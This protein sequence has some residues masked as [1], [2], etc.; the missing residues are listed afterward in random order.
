MSE[1]A[2]I[3]VVDDDAGTRETLRDVLQ[4]KGYAVD[5]ASRGAEGLE[6]LRTHPFDAAIVD[7]KLPDISGLEL[8]QALRTQAADI[9]VIFIT[10]Y[11]SLPTAIEAINGEAFAYLV[12]PFEMDHL[13]ATLHK[14]LNTQRLA[15]ALRES[16]ERYR[17]IAENIQDAVFLVDRESR[18]VFGNRRGEEISGY[19]EAEF[20]GR[21]ITDL[22]TPEGARQASER[23]AAA[24]SGRDPV[25]FFETQLVRKDGSLV[26]VEANMTTVVRHG[27]I[28]GR[29][30]V[31]RDISA[32]KRAEEQMRLRTTALEAAANAVV[33][34]DREGRIL[35]VNPAFTDL[36]GYTLAEAAGQTPRILKSGQH[37]AAFYRDLWETILAGRTWRGEIVNRHKDGSLC[38]EEQVLTSVRDERG[39]ITHF[40]AIKQ[41]VSERKRM[42]AQLI[43]SEKLAAMGQLLAGVAH[44]L[45]NPLSVVTGHAAILKS[46]GDPGVAGRAQ[47]MADAAERCARIV[48]NFLALA[49]QRPPERGRVAL[50][51]VVHEAVELLAYP[52]RV[53]SVEVALE[54]A[55]NLPALWADAHQLHQ[56]VVNLV[57]NAHHAVRE[58]TAP[59]RIALT[60]RR[61]AGGRRVVLE[62]A[63]SGRGIPREI[64]ARLFEP[65]FTTKPPGQ[66]TGLGLALCKGIVEAHGGSIEAASPPGSGAVFRV[67][68]PVESA[69]VAAAAARA[70]AASPPVRGQRI[71]V[72]DDEVEIAALL[73]EMLAADGHRVETA[74]NG[75]EALEKLGAG[76]H[77]LVISDLRMPELDGP[78]LYLEVARRH[79]ELLRR[80]VFVTGDTLGPESL[81]FLHR[82]NVPTL[83]KPFDLDDIRR[84]VQQ[85]LGAVQ[86]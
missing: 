34:T 57:S 68:L 64:Q 13:L 37:D 79:P 25:P 28:V 22:L 58:A 65:F 49:R 60:T 1:P 41:D 26:W 53:D 3:L 2:R 45:N 35:W 77:D 67:E 82:T 27:Q 21:P 24:D 29:L 70:A 31:V 38:T 23:L 10:G 80:M 44:E 12:K 36:S 66:G 20:V 11:A 48:R 76:G 30:G 61:E 84:V 78:G 59:R 50:D 81:E 83:G 86:F 39:E 71:L 75:V 85:V 14:A 63:D 17:L 18:L 62:V 16:E 74:A 15:R 19:T 52:L 43:Q 40:V 72:V 51:Q 56:V 73:S 46:T 9:E 33:I 47:K 69:P 42:Q 4:A 6:R 5:A 54:L 8:L 32:R 7:I 55:R